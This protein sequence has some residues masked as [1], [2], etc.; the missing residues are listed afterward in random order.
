MSYP[1]PPTP[2]W[3]L[4]K[5]AATYAVLILLDRVAYVVLAILMVGLRLWRWLRW[6]LAL[7]YVGLMANLFTGPPVIPLPTDYAVLLLTLWPL[8]FAVVGYRLEVYPRWTALVRLA[9]FVGL[10]WFM[11]EVHRHQHIKLDTSI[12]I[13]LCAMGNTESCES[14]KAWYA[15]LPPEW[16]PRPLADR[17]KL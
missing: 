13:V 9:V 5:A 6:A 1:R 17:G 8:M 3:D 16:Q 4:L 15:A 14:V 11:R 10:L 2:N 7:I 12:S